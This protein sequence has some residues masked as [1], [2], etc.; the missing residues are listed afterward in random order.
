MRN[1]AVPFALLI[2]VTGATLALALW[3]PFS[4]STSARQAGEPTT[5]DAGRGAAV[6]AAGCAGCH[7]AD[8]EGGIGP[9]LRGGGLTAAEVAAV[10]ASG[11]GTMPA[12]LV[13]GR[14][15]TD[16]AAYVA[17]LSE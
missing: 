13:T 12:G 17:T 6:F 9:A 5:G 3:H 15:A 11:R 4:P 2:V 7:G 16:V 14:E 1:P 10:V 8:A